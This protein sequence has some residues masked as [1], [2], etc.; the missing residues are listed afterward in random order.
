MVFKIFYFYNVQFLIETGYLD[1][2][3]V[4]LCDISMGS[5]RFS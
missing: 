1:C 4:S 2:L 5:L 3:D